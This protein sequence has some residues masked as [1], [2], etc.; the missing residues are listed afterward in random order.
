VAVRREW[1]G[2]RDRQEG[3]DAG[4]LGGITQSFIM[5]VEPGLSRGAERGLYGGVIGGIEG[6]VADQR[7]GLNMQRGT[8]SFGRVVAFP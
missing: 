5:R 6:G 4:Q 8:R 1:R 7:V 3:E 2:G